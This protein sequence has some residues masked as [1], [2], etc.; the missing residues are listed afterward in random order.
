M[1]LQNIHSAQNTFAKERDWEKFHTPKNL[2]MALSGET[3][4]LSEI[5]QWLTEAEAN[6]IMNNADKAESIRDE[7]ADIF[8]YVTRL[9]YVLNIDI[10]S[11][12][13]KKMKKNAEKYPVH[14]SKG[15]ATKYTD[16]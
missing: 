3:G 11:A 4:E 15:R 13:W 7:I 2:V 9:A 12:F 5:F 14:L 1:D 6:A 10:E 16:L 8:Y